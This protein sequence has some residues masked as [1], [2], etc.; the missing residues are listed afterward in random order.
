MATAARWRA[1]G[2]A[3]DA[4]FTADEA[5]EDAQPLPAE[6]DGDDEEEAE[7]QYRLELSRELQVRELVQA[8]CMH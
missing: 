7:R 5:S 2:R 1:G 4:L 8:M 3:A 6:A